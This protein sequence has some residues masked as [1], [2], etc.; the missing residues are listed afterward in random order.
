MDLP[1]K[2]KIRFFLMM[3]NPRFLRGNRGFSCE[4]KERN[5]LR[6]KRGMR[7][8]RREGRPINRTRGEREGLTSLKGDGIL[9]W[10]FG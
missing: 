5:E 1:R 3:M 4:K 10:L 8:G 6:E 9:T 2:L 7:V